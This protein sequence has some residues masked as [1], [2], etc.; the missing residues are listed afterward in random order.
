[1]STLILTTKLYVPPVRPERV[2]RPRLI[3]HLEA[4][5]HAGHRLY[6]VCARAGFGKNTVLSDWPGQRQLPAA[7]LFD[8]VGRVVGWMTGR[9]IDSA[10]A[11]APL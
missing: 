7:W 5:V 1:M 10:L 2:A 6:L 4:G 11:Q 9:Q 8:R 3:Q